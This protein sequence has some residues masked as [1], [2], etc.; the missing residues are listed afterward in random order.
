MSPRKYILDLSSDMS[1]CSIDPAEQYLFHLPDSNITHKKKT[2]KNLMAH[3]KLLNYSS[4]IYK[5]FQIKSYQNLV[6]NS[7]MYKRMQ[8]GAI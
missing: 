6:L 8:G 2:T 4:S 3:I 1:A 7:A 5:Y